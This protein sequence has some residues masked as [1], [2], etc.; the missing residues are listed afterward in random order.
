MLLFNPVKRC[1]TYSALQHDFFSGHVSL[2]NYEN[3]PPVSEQMQDFELA[4]PSAPEVGDCEVSDTAI[5]CP[6][7]LAA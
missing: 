6:G 7:M 2:V 1:S 5:N 4:V 3:M